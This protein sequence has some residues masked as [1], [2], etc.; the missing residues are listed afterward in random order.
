MILTSDQADLSDTRDVTLIEN[1][2]QKLSKSFSW[3]FFFFFFFS[4]NTRCPRDASGLALGARPRFRYAHTGRSRR[5]GRRGSVSSVLRRRFASPPPRFPT[6]RNESHKSR[7]QIA[8]APTTVRVPLALAA[9][10]PLPLTSPVARASPRRASSRSRLFYTR[11]PL[12]PVN[13]RPPVSLPR[14]F[15]PFLSS[16]SLSAP[17]SPSARLTFFDRRR[18]RRGP[19]SAKR[20][21]GNGATG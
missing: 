7:C 13:P 18:R 5:V 17:I 6:D 19:P 10:S 15:A 20:P 4:R 8:A 2:R 1:F 14:S 16:A 12:A 11:F 21:E 9:R 3:I